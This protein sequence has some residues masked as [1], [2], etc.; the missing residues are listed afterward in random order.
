MLTT[1]RRH[2]VGLF[3]MN[4]SPNRLPVATKAAITMAIPLAI[5]LLLHT[6]TSSSPEQGELDQDGRRLHHW[7]T[8]RP[9]QPSRPGSRFGQ[10]SR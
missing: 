5:A 1:A 6:R 10:I 4:E 8:D 7:D 9:W 2:A 3:A